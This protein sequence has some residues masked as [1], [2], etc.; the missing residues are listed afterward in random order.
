M[1]AGMHGIRGATRA[2]AALYTARLP[3]KCLELEERLEYP[4]GTFGPPVLIATTQQPR[5]D[6]NDW[7]AVIVVGQDTLD[8]TLED[9]QGPPILYRC[10]YRVFVRGADLDDTTRRRD[11]LT[12]AVRELLLPGA[13]LDDYAAEPG[14]VEPTDLRES[15]SDVGEDTRRRSI[16]AS[17][18]DATVIMEETLD[19]GPDGTIGQADTIAIHPA[20]IDD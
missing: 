7:P 2:L 18:I 12:L 9:A 20:L 14:H 6:G 4:A 8:I 5:L 16:A 19:P 11:D 17:Y 15:Y 10:R 3:A 13:L 1:M